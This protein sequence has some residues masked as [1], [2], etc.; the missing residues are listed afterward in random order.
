Y[1]HFDNS[2]PLDTMDRKGGNK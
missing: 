1:L 2:F